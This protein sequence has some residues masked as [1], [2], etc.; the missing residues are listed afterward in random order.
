MM[1][2]DP[3]RAILL[4]PWSTSVDLCWPPGATHAYQQQLYIRNQSP[5]I[6]YHPGKGARRGDVAGLAGR[7]AELHENAKTTASETSEPSPGTAVPVPGGSGPNI[8]GHAAVLELIDRQ[9]IAESAAALLSQIKGEAQTRRIDPA[10]RDP[11]HPPTAALRDKASAIRARPAGL[12][13]AVKQLSTVV[14]AIPAAA[15]R[16]T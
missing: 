15:C 12:A 13:I 3:A 2:G 8:A 5:A 11:A 1:A 14:N 9:S 16:A 4:R 7:G 10:P 6:L